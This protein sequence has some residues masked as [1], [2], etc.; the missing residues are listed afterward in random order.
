MAK[1]LTLY[2]EEPAIFFA[3]AL[4]DT[5]S[6]ETLYPQIILTADKFSDAIHGVAGLMTV[7]IICSQENET[8][9]E[10]IEK[11]VRQSLE[12]VFFRGEEIFLL[13][14]QKTELYQ[15]PASERMPL[16]VGATITFEIYEFPNAVTSDPDP[17]DAI[18]HWAASWDEN[19]TVI[20]VSEFKE[21]FEPTHEKPAV[22]FD[23][24]ITR[25]AEQQHALVW[26]D[27]VI[28]CH[29]FAPKV[30]SRREW[31]TA[32]NHAL[33]FQG[34]VRMLDNLPMRLQGAEQNFAATEIEGQ[35]KLSFQFGLRR[36]QRYAHTLMERNLS[37][38]ENIRRPG[39]WRKTSFPKRNNEGSN[40]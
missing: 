36:K 3:K 8:T 24:Q 15:E 31:L 10:P 16:I 9:P 19:L 22:Y 35:L 6:P 26:V 5:D 13:K 37:F 39:N 28:N 17:I 11:L 32:I 2:G 12:G 34:A 21:I 30:K 38:D 1:T 23:L 29:V 25:L 4:A 33:M 27:C 14:W 7:D 18:N 20:G 40:S